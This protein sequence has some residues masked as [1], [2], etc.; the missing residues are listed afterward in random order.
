MICGRPVCNVMGTAWVGY[1]R[2][3]PDFEICR[4]YSG[5]LGA[6][7]YTA[8][9]LFYTSQCNHA[10]LG[11]GGTALPTFMELLRGYSVT[12]YT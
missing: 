7:A 8:R 12:C 1:D 4:P 10:A 11:S 5:L 2:N 6:K 3:G 9:L